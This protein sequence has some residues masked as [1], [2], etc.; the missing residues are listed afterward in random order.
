VAIPFRDLGEVIGRRLNAPV[1]AKNSE[2]AANHFGLF[3]HFA[4]LDC[5]VSSQ[6]TRGCWD[7]NRNSPG[8]FS[9]W[10]GRRATSKRSRPHDV[11]AIARSD[12]SSPKRDDHC[13]GGAA[14]R[15]RKACR[16]E[17][18]SRKNSGNGG[19]DVHRILH[20]L[21]ASAISSVSPPMTARPSVYKTT[22]H[23]LSKGEQ[24]DGTT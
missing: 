12:H 15:H 2:E 23:F 19:C 6:S 8:S 17:D 20:R 13:D 7:G 1:V 16:D 11:R 22:Q 4:G 9:I 3:A 24:H 10:N 21:K 18:Q 5:P 14:W